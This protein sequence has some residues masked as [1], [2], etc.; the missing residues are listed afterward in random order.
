M[1]FNDVYHQ[2]VELL[3]RM[4]PYVAEEECFALKGGTAIN[5]FYRDM[6]RLSVDIDLTYLPLADRDESLAS[7]EA[8]LQRIAVSI[9]ST[10]A[11]ARIT[12]SSPKTQKTT[13]KLLVRSQN[14]QI[15]IEVNPIL[16]GSVNEPETMVITQK[17]EDEFGFAE[18]NVLSFADIYAGKIMAALDRQHPRDLFDVHQLLEN[19]GITEEIHRALMVYF[20]SH[21]HSPAQLLSAECRNIAHDYQHNFYGMTEED[22]AIST[23]IAAHADLEREL[24]TNMKEDHKRFLLS[25]YR[26]EPEWEVLGIEGADKLPAVRWREINLDRAGKETRAAIVK[27]LEQ[28]LS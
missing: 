10:D 5:L 2:Q 12:E 26:R 24:V 3:I 17:A 19:E 25:F 6:P 14:V 20:V 16:R 18:N 9:R 22:I 7:I 1:P 8:A 13:D 28:V 15:K 21:A 23:L 27:N 11:G 4:L